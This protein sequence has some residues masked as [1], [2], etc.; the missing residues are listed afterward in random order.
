MPVYVQPLESTPFRNDPKMHICITTTNIIRT[1]AIN[2]IIR[3]GHVCLTDRT[4]RISFTQLQYV[5]YQLTYN[6]YF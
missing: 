3:N 4:T 5:A 2:Y 1:K 6:C